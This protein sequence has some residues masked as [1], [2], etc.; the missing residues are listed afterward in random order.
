MC[1][2]THI[3]TQRCNSTHAPTQ[4]VSRHVMTKGSVKG[5]TTRK[6]GDCWSN[7]IC[8]RLICHCMTSPRA[9]NYATRTQVVTAT[10]THTHTHTRTHA[11]TARAHTHTHTYARRH[12]THIHTHTGSHAH[13]HTHTPSM[14]GFMSLNLMS[15]W[16]VGPCATA[17]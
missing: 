9:V 16:T 17:E 13:T 10:R 3:P 15:Q 4:T 1:T 5:D 11:R 12:T 14:S 7:A 2:Y 6:R 8:L